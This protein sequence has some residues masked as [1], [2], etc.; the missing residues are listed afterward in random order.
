MPFYSLDTSSILEWYVRRYPPEL[1]PGLPGRVEDLIAA[2]RLRS[3][4]VVLDEIRPGDA[5]HGWAHGQT[6]LFV[7]ESVEV[8]LAVRQLMARHHD[9]ARPLKGIQNADPFVIALAMVGGSDWTVVTD[10]HPGSAENRKIPY[11]CDREGVTCITFQG[12]MRAE[13]WQFY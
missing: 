10:E 4:R 1:L 7:E 3:P 5:V 13:R 12:L 6:D 8:Q 9:P 11:V 2:G